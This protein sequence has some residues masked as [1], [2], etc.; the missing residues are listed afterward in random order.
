MLY[1]NGTSVILSSWTD[2]IWLWAVLSHTMMTNLKYVPLWSCRILFPSPS[3]PTKAMRETEP[4]RLTHNTSY[5]FVFP[6][7][8]YQSYI[9]INDG[10]SSITQLYFVLILCYAIYAHLAYFDL[11]HV[12]EEVTPPRRL[13]W[14]ISFEDSV[15]SKLTL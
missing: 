13:L 8:I 12:T 10:I 11:F 5:A 7:S 1:I 9:D 6:L 3:A 2:K 14:F 15:Q 4:H